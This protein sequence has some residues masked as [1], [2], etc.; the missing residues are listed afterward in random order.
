VEAGTYDEIIDSISPRIVNLEQIEAEEH[1]EREVEVDGEADRE[2][3]QTE[4]WGRQGRKIRWDT[5]RGAEA[6]DI[7]LKRKER[8]HFPFLARR[9][10]PFPSST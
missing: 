6:D 10:N 8:E 1:E 9:K 5:R 7:A 4:N 3:R 2:E